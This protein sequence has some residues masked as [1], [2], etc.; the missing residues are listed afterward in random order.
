MKATIRM[1]YGFR[2]VDNLIAMIKLRCSG[3]PTHL[4]TPIL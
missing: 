1:A 2:H 4:P 3:L